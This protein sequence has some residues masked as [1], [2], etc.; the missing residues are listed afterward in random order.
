LVVSVA[1]GTYCGS[2]GCNPRTYSWYIGRPSGPTWPCIGVRSAV[3]AIEPPA[4][5]AAGL[6][7]CRSRRCGHCGRY[8]GRHLD[9]PHEATC[10]G[11]ETHPQG[12]ERVAGCRDTHSGIISRR[13]VDA[14]VSIVL[15]GIEGIADIV[16]VSDVVSGV[17]VVIEVRHVGSQWVSYATVDFLPFYM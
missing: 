12:R 5:L 9:V 17:G 16:C 11:R 3:L 14:V 1:S 7:A 15:G 13:F 2:S 10:G 4:L 8:F 6:P